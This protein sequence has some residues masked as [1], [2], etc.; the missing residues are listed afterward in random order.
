MMCTC[1]HSVYEHEK[2]RSCN[3]CGCKMFH[4]IQKVRSSPLRLREGSEADQFIRDSFGQFQGEGYQMVSRIFRTDQAHQHEFNE[5]FNMMSSG[6]YIEFKEC[7]LCGMDIP[8]R[9]KLGG[10]L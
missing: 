7:R 3:M 9:R 1:G 10:K 6:K 8:T 5:P 2:N 4:D